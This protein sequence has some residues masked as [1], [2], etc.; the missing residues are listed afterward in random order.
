MNKLLTTL[1]LSSMLVG[2]GGEEPEPSNNIVQESVQEVAPI[3]AKKKNV[4]IIYADDLGWGQVGFNGQK[5]IITPEL[6]KIAKTAIKFNNFYTSAPF[7]PPARNGL[8]TGLDG[9]ETVWRVNDM[10]FG[11]EP[12]MAQMFKSHG[13][14][15]SMFGKWGMSTP[16][17]SPSESHEYKLTCSNMDV[18]YSSL[19]YEFERMGDPI[20][21]GF[22]SFVGYMDHRDAHVYYHDSPDHQMGNDRQEGTGNKPYVAD[23]IRQDLFTIKD[24]EVV[25]FPTNPDMY[26]ADV[27]TYKALEH[28]DEVAKTGKPFFMYFPSQLPHAELVTPPNYEGLYTDGNG[29]SIFEEV[30]F[31]GDNIY[32]RHVDDPR[33][34]LARMIT[35]LDVHVAWLVT[36]LK[37]LGLYEDTIIVFSSDNGHH[38]A[39]GIGNVDYFDSNAGMRG[40]KWELH[41]GGIK[42]PT[43]VFGGGIEEASV[44]TRYAQHQLKDTFE[45]LLTGNP[46]PKSILPVFEG[47]SVPQQEYLYWQ[48]LHTSGYGTSPTRQAVIDGNWKL[49]RYGKENPTYSLYDLRQKH[50]EYTDYWFQDCNKSLR[51]LN[52][53]NDRITNNEIPKGSRS[54]EY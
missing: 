13:Y 23:V 25:R 10:Q 50:N 6:D 32:F 39:G 27:I 26:L 17:M 33:A 12:T 36:K 34:T 22:D 43:L 8:M 29:N 31:K 49:V 20:Q 53:L 9:G 46:K 47:K 41:E 1:V 45:E 40:Q 51:L 48:F 38:T 52:Y 54:C 37:D 30:P 42:V 4:L 24:D 3:P 15:T 21:A 18:F 2:C 44:D 5:K 28:L 19:S 14:D 7:C 35:R 16:K 11:R